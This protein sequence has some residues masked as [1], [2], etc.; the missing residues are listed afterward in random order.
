[1]T[2]AEIPVHRIRCDSSSRTENWPGQAT[3]RTFQAKVPT[4]ATPGT[5]GPPPGR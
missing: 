1:M 5:G 4:S 3:V 2:T